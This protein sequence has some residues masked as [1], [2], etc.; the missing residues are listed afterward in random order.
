MGGVTGHTPGVSGLDIKDIVSDGHFQPA[1]DQVSGLLMG[2]GMDG[3]VVTPGQPELGQKCLVTVHQGLDQY[4]RHGL[5]ESIVL[6][7]VKH[8]NFP[9]NERPVL[10]G[11]VDFCQQRLVGFAEFHKFIMTAAFVR[12]VFPSQ[13]SEF[14]GQGPF[15]HGF[16]FRCREIENYPGPGPGH[17]RFRGLMKK[18][19]PEPEILLH[20][21]EQNGFPIR[22]I[23][24]HDHVTDQI[25]MQVSGS[26][27]K[28]FVQVAQ[29]LNKIGIHLV[30][31]QGMG[32]FFC[33]KAFE[34]PLQ[35]KYGV[36]IGLELPV[37]QAGFLLNESLFDFIPAF[38]LKCSEQGRRHVHQRS[39]I[40]VA[41]FEKMGPALVKG[42]GRPGRRFFFFPGHAPIGG[43]F[44]PLPEMG[45]GLADIRPD[46]RPE[47]VFQF[48][49]VKLGG[50][51]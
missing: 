30:L 12:V 15:V 18:M 50:L 34:K 45:R 14:A 1:A 22:M 42:V 33:Q 3:Q 38:S 10:S 49:G 26:M 28:A 35:I 47:Q 24:K 43:G 32:H 27:K 23:K 4:S 6:R 44:V 20:F 51:F 17:C 19:A 21:F 41:E 25:V 29:L 13:F 9:F 8:L 46:K 37:T 36:D 39:L 7:F 11:W 40:H 2:V 48:I 5:P 16:E 31:I